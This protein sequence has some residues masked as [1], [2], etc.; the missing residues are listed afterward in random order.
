MIWRVTV[1]DARVVEK[2]YEVEADDVNVEEADEGP[3]ER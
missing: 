2:T 3:V 1:Q